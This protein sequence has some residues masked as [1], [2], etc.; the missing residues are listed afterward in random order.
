MPPQPPPPP[1]AA[2]LEPQQTPE[3]AN[4]N[5][6]VVNLQAALHHKGYYH[7]RLDGKCGPQTQRAIAH[8]QHNLNVPPTTGCHVDPKTWSALGLSQGDSGPHSN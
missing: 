6:Y 8:F 4:T 5:A 1:P 7:G 2:Q 3:T